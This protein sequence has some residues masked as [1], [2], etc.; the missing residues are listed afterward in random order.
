VLARRTAHPERTGPGADRVEAASATVQGPDGVDRVGLG[1][2]LGR[3]SGYLP[4][5]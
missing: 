4:Q 3:E 5:S 2:V 1:G